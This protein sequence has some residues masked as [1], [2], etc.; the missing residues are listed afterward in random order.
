MSDDKDP[1]KDKALHQLMEDEFQ[2]LVDIIEQ[3]KIVHEDIDLT[4]TP[5]D[6]PILEVAMRLHDQSEELGAETLAEFFYAL[7]GSTRNGDLHETAELL[8]NISDEFESVKKI[9]DGD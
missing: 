6:D 9:L 1:L 4:R 2:Q 3:K 7:E 5:A 8:K